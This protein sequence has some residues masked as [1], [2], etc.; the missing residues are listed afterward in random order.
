M[1]LKTIPH[2]AT[3]ALMLTACAVT[4]TPPPVPDALRPGGGATLAMSTTARGVQIYECR[5]GQWAFVAPQ[6]ELFDAAGRTIGTH[7]AGPYWEASDGSRVVASV[8][9]R[10][11]APVAGAIPWL[12]LAARPDNGAPV[13][14]GLLAGITHIQR[15][16]TAGGTAPAG[17]CH[18]PGQP[19]R[20]PYFAAY[21]FYRNSK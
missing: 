4:P 15:V 17:V 14:N 6:A 7:G 13:T 9:S 5:A 1:S 12:L 3:A 8:S 20:V 10:A 11:D 21:H 2:A 19:L 18:A 16:D